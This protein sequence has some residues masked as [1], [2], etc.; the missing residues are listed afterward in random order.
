[1]KIKHALISTT[2]S[3]STPFISTPQTT[4]SSTSIPPLFDWI[5]LR[6]GML[7]DEDT[8][9]SLLGAYGCASRGFPLNPFDSSAGR[10]VDGVDKVLLRW[11]KCIRCAMS[12]E[13]DGRTQLPDYIWPTNEICGMSKYHMIRLLSRKLFIIE[14]WEDLKKKFANAT[15]KLQLLF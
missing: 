14:K 7:F 4:S 1:M 3:T 5:L 11:K 2:A 6:L 9:T 8:V 13:F 10:P 15:S 12:V